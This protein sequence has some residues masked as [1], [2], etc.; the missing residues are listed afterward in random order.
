MIFLHPYTGIRHDGTLYAGDA[1]LR[2]LPNGFRDDLYFSYGSQGRFTLLPALYAQLIELFGIGRGTMVGMLVAFVLYFA[3]SWYLVRSFAPRTWTPFCVLSVVCGWTIYGGNR[4]FGY[5]ESFLT[6]RSFAEP[7]VLLGLA[8]LINE[9]RWAAGVALLVALLIHPLIAIAGCFV[10]W[11]ILARENRR[12]L[13][14]LPIGLAALLVLGAIGREPFSDVFARYDPE[15]LALVHEANGHAFVLRWSM[16]DYG[17]VLFD[18]TILY[19]AVRLAIHRR[20]SQLAIAVGVAGLVATLSSVL[21]VD[22]VGNPFFGKLQIW[23]VEWI[24]QWTAM[25]MLPLVLRELWRVRGEHG[26]LVACFLAIGWIA[27]FSVAPGILAIMAIAVDAARTRITISRN[28][29]RL[30]AGIVIL[31]A[32]VIAVQYEARLVKLGILLDQPL[33]LIVGQAFTMNLL[34]AGGAVGLVLLIP[35]LGLAAPLVAFLILVCAL[36]LWDQRGPWARRLESYPTGTHIW[37]DLIAP[38]AR[39]YWYR[40]LIAPW[41]LLGHG[42]YYT[43][44]QG[45]GAVFSRDMVVELD[46]RRK[47]TALLDF[48][49]QICRMMNNLSEKEASCE[50]DAEAVATVCEE[51]N[52]DYVVLQSTLEG[53]APLSSFSTGIVEN[54]Y[55][56]KFFLYRCSSLTK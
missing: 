25:A 53:R 39:V 49:E 9:R 28:T 46:R 24:M 30:V 44:Q 36:L 48:Q 38:D 56:K 7:A 6:A 13:W 43:Q 8:L 11:I 33:A 21:L 37:A 34:I 22:L 54:G 15:W 35:R 51:G 5:S 1:L 42:N 29:T 40:D 52:I 27:T 45:S 50:P 12:W 20:V 3:A 23:R 32:V 26:R 17:V 18:A 19:F 14:L 16:L 10:A 55:E 2:L 4:I 31:T 41:I 47:I